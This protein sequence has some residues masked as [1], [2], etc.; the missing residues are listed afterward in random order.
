MRSHFVALQLSF[1][2]STSPELSIYTTNQVER[3]NS[4]ISLVMNRNVLCTAKQGSQ[5]QVRIAAP[6]NNNKHHPKCHPLNWKT[7]K[8]QN[9]LLWL[10]HP[11]TSPNPSHKGHRL[12]LKT[13]ETAK[14]CMPQAEDRHDW[15]SIHQLWKQHH[16]SHRTSIAYCRTRKCIPLFGPLYQTVS[17]NQPYKRILSHSRSG[18]HSDL[19]NTSKTLRKAWNS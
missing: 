9:H 4:S 19:G 1:R 14:S 7:L 5:A 13:T 12:Q 10:Q 16:L 18:N 11:Q 6:V 3:S 17:A 15:G 2:E 8:L